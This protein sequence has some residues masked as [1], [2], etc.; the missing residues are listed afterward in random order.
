MGTVLGAHLITT[1][2]GIRGMM[3]LAPIYAVPDARLNW[4]W[5][6]RHVMPWYYPHKSK[7][8]TMQ[9]LVRERV[10]DFDPTLD[11]DS[12]EVQASLPQ[13]ARVPTSGLAEMVAM[14]RY[15]RSLWPQLTLPIHIFQGKQDRAVAASDTK[16]L[17]E[18][19]P[20][21]DKKLDLFPEAGH[22]LMRPSDPVHEQVWPTIEAFITRHAAR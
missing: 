16:I 2:G 12:P 14:V 11:F 20:S 21:Q 7:K 15:G 13:V 17:F 19:L 1:Q 3:M 6:I 9:K 5:L 8:P 22:E 18:L 10:L 4:M